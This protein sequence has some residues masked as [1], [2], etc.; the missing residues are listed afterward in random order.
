MRAQ[1]PTARRL[2]RGRCLRFWRGVVLVVAALAALAIPCGAQGSP[3]TPAAPDSLE[4]LAKARDRVQTFFDQFSNVACTEAV[5][6]IVLG[7]KG[8][9]SY[10]ENSAY[11]Y[12]FLATSEGG[13]MKV[14][15]SRNTHNPA[16]R[17]PGRTLLITNGFA[18][19]LLVV[20]PMY[21]ASYTFEPAGEESLGG[22]TLA[23][24]HFTPV[25]G[26]TS[27]AALRLRGKNYPLPLSGTLWIE[28][29]TGVIVKL[30]AQVDSS[31]SEL[32]LAGLQTEV[33]Y[34][35][36]TFHDPDE[37]MWIPESA[38]IDVETPRQHW[39]NLHHFKDYKRFNVGV[40]EEIGQTR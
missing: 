16:F 19:I 15:E 31:L 13:T 40:H 6:Q 18:S 32:G 11:D 38:V 39:R 10:R 36:H 5:T 20:H 21:E 1:L 7:Q 34:A 8:R 2:T 29:Q 14:T 26:A 27:P 24:I 35:P 30:E 37:T 12:Q 33:R 3:D 23:K 28:P 9:L 25:A 17:D 4:A 22:A